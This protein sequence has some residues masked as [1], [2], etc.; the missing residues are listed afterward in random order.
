MHKALRDLRGYDLAIAEGK[1]KTF[2]VHRCHTAALQKT[3]KFSLLQHDYRS[4]VPWTGLCA[5]RASQIHKKTRATYSSASIMHGTC[6]ALDTCIHPID[7]LSDRSSSSQLEKLGVECKS[8]ICDE[9]ASNSTTNDSEDRR[10]L[11]QL[12]SL[13]MFRQSQDTTIS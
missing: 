3:A 12:H 13:M 6:A 8:V 4:S 2:I 10:S 9:S 1:P 7:Q 5:V 11:Y